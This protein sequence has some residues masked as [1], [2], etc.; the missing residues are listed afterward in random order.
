MSFFRRPNIWNH[1]HYPEKSKT[2]I[3]TAPTGSQLSF[4]SAVLS[5]RSGGAIS[6]GIGFKTDDTRWKAG[7][8]V[9]GSATYTDDTT[10]AQ[11]SG[12]NDFALTTTTNNDGFIIQSLDKFGIVGIQV[13]TAQAGTPVYEYNY[14]NGSAYASLSTLEVP[15]SYAVGEVT[16]AFSPPLDWAPVAAGTAPAT[17]GMDVGKYVIRVRATTAPSTA[18]LASLIWVS[19]FLSFKTAVATDTLL[20]IIASDTQ[21][22][23]ILNGGESIVPYFQTANAN[24]SVEVE[25][26]IRG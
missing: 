10:D 9:N 21:R 22:G 7:Q 13:T 16:I 19:R 1:T 14:W 6:M 26:Y 20:N 24:N 4:I 12:T 8:W 17:S 23:F 2:A 5:N 3:A 18:P 15:A 11:D 25:Y